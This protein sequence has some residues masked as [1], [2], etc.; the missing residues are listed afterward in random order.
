MNPMTQKRLGT[1]SDVGHTSCPNML[2]ITC[3]QTTR[4]THFGYLWW[5]SFMSLDSSRRELSNSTGDVYHRSFG[6]PLRSFYLFLYF[7]LSSRIT[8]RKKKRKE[9]L[10]AHQ[11]HWKYLD[12]MNA[13]SSRKDH[14]RLPKW[15]TRA[16]WR[17]I[18]LNTFGQLMWLIPVTI[19]DLPWCLWICFVDIF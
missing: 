16:F 19:D 12:E 18:S 5:S 14:Q 2:D 4:I 13:T 6:V 8:G 7:S 17:R 3:L 11:Y 1:I 15:T 10:E 9:I